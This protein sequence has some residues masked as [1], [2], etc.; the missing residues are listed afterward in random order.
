[1]AEPRRGESGPPGRHMACRQWTAVLLPPLRGSGVGRVVVPGAYAPG[2]M[3]PP[4]R[5]SAIRPRGDAQ[6]AA[7]LQVFGTFRDAQ[8]AARLIWS[9]P[10]QG[11]FRLPGQGRV[12][13]LVRLRRRQRMG[14]KI[15]T[16]CHPDIRGLLRRG[17]AEPHCNPPTSGSAIY[18]RESVPHEATVARRARASLARGRPR[19]AAL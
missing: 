9:T 10:R 17:G 14:R 18:G 12:G 7:R 1:M 13:L 16:S 4:L 6:G 2:Y 3:L 5:G 8:G 15:S 11:P 19:S